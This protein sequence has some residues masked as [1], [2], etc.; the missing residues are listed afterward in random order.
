MADA[1]KALARWSADDEVD[2]PM[3]DPEY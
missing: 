2:L 3:V 1:R